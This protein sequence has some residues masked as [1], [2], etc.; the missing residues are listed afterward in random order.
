MPREASFYSL[1]VDVDEL[2]A[3]LGVEDGLAGVQSP[4]SGAD[5]AHRTHDRVAQQSVRA[6][7]LNADEQRGD[8]EVR[9]AAEKARD[10]ERRGKARGQAEQRSRRAAEGRADK[11]RGTVL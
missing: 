8:G 5:I 6:E 9:H 3:Q 4:V 11:E 7:Q 2:R 1:R 10:A